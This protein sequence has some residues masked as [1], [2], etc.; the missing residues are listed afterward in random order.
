MQYCDSK[1]QWCARQF[2]T[3]LKAREAMM[4]KPHIRKHNP[5][6]NSNIISSRLKDGSRVQYGLYTGTV[7]HLSPY[8]GV[9][10]M[11]WC[12]VEFELYGT[13]W[14][15]TVPVEELKNI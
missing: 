8:R 6:F 1:C 2:W 11:H 9:D 4:S 5:A 10:G 15:W 3:W 7:R 14:Y 12:R 13:R